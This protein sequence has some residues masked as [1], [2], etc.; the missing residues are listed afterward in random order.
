MTQVH[1]TLKQEEIQITVPYR[2]I[3]PMLYLPTEVALLWLFLR[4]RSSQHYGY[5]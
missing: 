4:P 2:L 5:A 3:V 1:F